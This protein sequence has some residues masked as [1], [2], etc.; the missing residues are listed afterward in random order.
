MRTVRGI[1][2]MEWKTERTQP[3]PKSDNSRQHAR[4]KISIPKAGF[5]DVAIEESGKTI[6]ENGVYIGGSPGIFSG[7]DAADDVTF[8]TGSGQFTFILRG[9]K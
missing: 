1:I 5:H 9:M 6:W 3:E 7:V 4:A 2:S 8:D